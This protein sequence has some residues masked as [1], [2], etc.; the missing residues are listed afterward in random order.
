MEN[1]LKKHVPNGVMAVTTAEPFVIRACMK[2]SRDNGLPFAVEATVNQVNQFGGYTGMRPKDYAA[3]VMG[4][5]DGLGFPRDRVFLCGDHLG[6]F[7]WQNLPEKEAMQ[8]SRDLVREYVLAGFRKIHLDPTMRLADDDHNAPLPLETIARRVVDL[9]KV[10]EA[11]YAETAA[12]AP[13][14]PVYVVGSEVPTPGGT[15][16]D[17]GMQVTKPE[18]LRNSIECFK[19]ALNGNGLGQVW[20]DMVAVV[21]QIGVEF[22]DDSIH[23]YIHEA[24]VAL[25]AE[26]ERNY[27]ALRFESHSSDYQTFSRL[28]EMVR[29]RVGIL[30]VGPGLTFAM[31]EGLFALA[32]MEEELRP[33]RGY[34]ASGFI[35]VLDR[36]MLESTPN[37]WEKYYHGTEEEKALKRKYSYSDRSRYYFAHPDIARARKQ[38]L[39]NLSRSPLPLSLVS[40]YMPYQ[41]DR[42]REGKLENKAELLV[43]D[44]VIDV[45]DRYCSAIRAAKEAK[46]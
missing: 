1:P 6:P 3:M 43:E 17:E 23:D 24:A 21:A 39:D 28:R 33:S 32:M 36:V 35:R 13:Y 25:A 26:L 2:Y 18:D 44:K 45:M 41:Y 19:S 37:Y 5:A 16:E 14:R 11:A 30:K 42:I 27:P 9:A 7:V 34:E 20:D 31:R 4:I 46:A 12:S 29:D 8:R 40:Q 38:L 22:A 15:E 10:S